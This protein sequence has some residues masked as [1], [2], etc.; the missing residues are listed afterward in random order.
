MNIHQWDAA[1][2]GLCCWQAVCKSYRIATSKFSGAEGGEGGI[3]CSSIYQTEW[4]PLVVSLCV[5]YFKNK[6]MQRQNKRIFWILYT[7]LLLQCSPPASKKRKEEEK[8]SSAFVRCNFNVISITWAIPRLIKCKKKNLRGKIIKKVNV[9]AVK[10]KK[11][12]REEKA[13]LYAFCL[14]IKAEGEEKTWC[15]VNITYNSKI[16]EIR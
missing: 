12:K 6:G 13:L 8:S 4:R 10:N 3:N 11:E 2:A 14:K 15:Y 16:I 7:S 5:L 9:R 1:A